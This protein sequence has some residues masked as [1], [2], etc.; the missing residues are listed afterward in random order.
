MKSIRIFVAAFLMMS[1]AVSCQPSAEELTLQYKE[2][3]T[4]YASAKISGD[5]VRAE[6]LEDEMEQL[7][8]KI[9]KLAQKEVRKTK[10][11]LKKT[12]KK[13]EKSIDKGIKEVEDAVEDIF[14]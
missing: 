9:E 8:E 10:K 7:N 1:V 12:G 13:V 2:L 11:E 5:D 14:K 3:A 4:E 6:Q